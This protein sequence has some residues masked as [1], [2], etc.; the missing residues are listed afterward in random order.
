MGVDLSS[1]VVS[2]DR[3][4]SKEDCGLEEERGLAGQAMIWMDGELR[5][6]SSAGHY[7]GQLSGKPNRIETVS[8]K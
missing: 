2:F 3:I 8:V 5:D 7:I 6:Q 4:E 1:D